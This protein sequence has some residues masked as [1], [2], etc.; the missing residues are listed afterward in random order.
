MP[1]TSSVIFILHKRIICD[2]DNPL[3]MTNKTNNIIKILHQTLF[4]HLLKSATIF[5]ERMVL[6][7]SGKRLCIVK[8]LKPA[9]SYSNQGYSAQAYFANKK[10]LIIAPL[11]H[12]IKFLGES[13]AIQHLI[14]QTMLKQLT[15]C[16]F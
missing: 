7:K 3:Q 5:F 6:S 11:P 2:D 9:G 1:M 4:Q 14:C 13:C 12:K 16:C 15:N 10:I 8:M